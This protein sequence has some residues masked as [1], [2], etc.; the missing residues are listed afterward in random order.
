MHRPYRAFKQTLYI[1]LGHYGFRHA[2]WLQWI[3]SEIGNPDFGIFSPGKSY[4]KQVQAAIAAQ[5]EKEKQEEIE[6]RLKKKNKGL[7]LILKIR[8]LF[9]L[10]EDA[11]DGAAGVFGRFKTWF[12]LLVL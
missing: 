10:A 1:S 11:F 7:K 12:F 5:L 9:R 8:G 6:S 2:I 4:K 3:K